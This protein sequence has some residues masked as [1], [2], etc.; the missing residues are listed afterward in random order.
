M[1]DLQR[2]AKEASLQSLTAAMDEDDLKPILTIKIEAG[3]GASVGGKP[4]E[5]PLSFPGEPDGD[6]GDALL[7]SDDGDD[8]PFMAMVKKKMREKMGQ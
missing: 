8:D 4:D 6:E 7:G 1:N 3:G 2:K 5:E